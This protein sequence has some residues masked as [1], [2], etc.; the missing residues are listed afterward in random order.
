MT[1][2]G[3]TLRN[4]FFYISA[5][6]HFSQSGHG[7]LQSAEE[8]GGAFSADKYHQHIR[9]HNNGLMRENTRLMLAIDILD[10]DPSRTADEALCHSFAMSDEVFVCRYPEAGMSYNQ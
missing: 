5:Y 6:A 9:V 8:G 4:S 7:A 10:H 3:V 2:L 1:P